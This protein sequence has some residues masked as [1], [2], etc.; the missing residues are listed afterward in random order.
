V[1]Q[2]FRLLYKPADVLILLT[3]AHLLACKKCDLKVDD[4][5]IVAENNNRNLVDEFLN[6][7]P[8]I[9]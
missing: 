3:A 1:R 2:Y 8:G 5:I 9:T 7:Y 4:K 6:Y